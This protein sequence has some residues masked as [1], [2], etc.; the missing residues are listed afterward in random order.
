MITSGADDCV[1]FR[2]HTLLL[3]DKAGRCEYVE[4]TLSN[5][6]SDAV[7][8]DECMTSTDD[9]NNADSVTEK[10]QRPFHWQTKQFRFNFT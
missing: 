4:R 3:I 2:T 9:N 1:L 5:C 8:L 10:R 6:N 7:G